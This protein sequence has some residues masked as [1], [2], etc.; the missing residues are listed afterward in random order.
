MREN[1]YSIYLPKT[2]ADLK[3]FQKL[4]EIEGKILEEERI[5]K[6][7]LV[8]N[9]WI[10]TANRS[11]LLRMAN[12]MKLFVAE[13]METEALRQEVLSRWNNHGP[14]TWF[15][16]SDWLDG[17]CGKDMYWLKCLHGEYRLQLTLGLQIKEKKEFLEAYLRKIIPA[18]LILEIKLNT[19]THRR[20]KPLT[21]GNIKQMKWTYGQIPYEDLTI[22]QNQG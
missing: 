9:Q 15:H 14:Y 17:C 16:L 5:A 4:G 19:N 2:V 13:D 3:E 11:G 10:A 7:T 21:H 8:R 6:D 1:R 12:M 18:N 22:Y 20:L